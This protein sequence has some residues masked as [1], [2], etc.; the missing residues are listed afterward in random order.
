MVEVID[1]GIGI[2]PLEQALVFNRF[3]RSSS[4]TGRGG[5]GLGLYLA[6]HIAD[7][8]G[9]AVELDSA[10]GQGSRFRLVLP[11]SS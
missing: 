7:A 10:P 11:V 1:H 4:L 8:H 6:K 2:D 5:Y 3:Y 9:G